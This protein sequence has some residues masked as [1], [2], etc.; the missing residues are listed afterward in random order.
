MGKKPLYRQVKEVI[1]AKID[2]GEL[3]AWMRGGLGDRTGF[4]PE[5]LEADGELGPA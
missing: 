3:S 4:D 1:S 5:C 2:S